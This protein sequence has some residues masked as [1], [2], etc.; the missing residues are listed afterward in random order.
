MILINPKSTKFGIFE[1]YVPLS[2]PIGVGCLAAYLL[3]HGRK[4]EIIDEHIEPLS[5]ELIDNALERVSRPYIF[6]ISTLT[7]CAKRSYDISNRIKTW[8]PDSV[9]V[10]GGIHPTVLAEEALANRAV[11]F[12][13]RGEAEKIL[14]EL[15]DAVKN[16]GDHSR[17]RGLSYKD[18][19]KPVH[20]PP[21]DLPDL[22]DFPVFP[23]H[24]FEK[25]LGKYNFGFIASSRGCPYDCIFCSQRAISGQ[26]FRYVPEKT[27]IEE[28]GLLIN[29]YGQTHINFV[30]DNFT[31]NKQR[32]SRLCELMI[33]SGFHRKAT[34]DCQTRADA[35]DDEILTLLKKAG[36]RVV[37]YGLETAS[38]RLMVMLNKKETVAENIA[39]VKL[40]KKH[41]FKVSGT[42]IF[43][44]P[45]ETREE[46]WQAY[47]LAKKLDLDYVRFNNATP[48]PG[49]RL[50]E[51]AK[52]E[53]RL[54]VE[55]GWTNLNACA[56]L[57]QD[58]MTESKLPYVPK[59]CDE[60]ELK[61]DIIRANLL[62]S[63]RPKRVFRLLTKRI[64]PA[65]WF[66]LPSRWYLSFK[67][68][69]C[70]I[71]LGWSLLNSLVK[72]YT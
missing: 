52:E 2:V 42:F 50:Y 49:T 36:F 21:A 31:A 11:D 72:I 45:T 39:A 67:E 56:S 48:Y 29:K 1:R 38:E 53:G 46:R 34:F 8:Y 10:L 12:A 55:E 62:F 71:R 40:A 61:K 30:D 51:I 57:V 68:W 28:I 19:G 22:D 26:K 65:G 7:A 17:I 70:L 43:G 69:R 54:F 6:G 59:G 44:L 47:E 23:Y 58:S 15:Y 35:V 24:L 18:G 13:V 14:L 9:I 66:Y 20:N 63:L 4:V 64:G 25:Y 41:D 60:K 3:Q 37:N 5:K 33:K 27:V 32:I 16:N